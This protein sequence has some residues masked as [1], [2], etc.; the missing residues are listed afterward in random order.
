MTTMSSNAQAKPEP[1]PEKYRFKKG[2]FIQ[3]PGLGVITEEHL[4]NPNVIKALKKWDEKK[5]AD[6]FDKLVEKVS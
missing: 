2:K 6:F 1:K 3:H 4:S 5:K